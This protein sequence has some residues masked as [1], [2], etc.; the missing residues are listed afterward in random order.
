MGD[1]D[2]SD[3]FDPPVTPEGKKLREPVTLK[4]IRYYLDELPPLATDQISFLSP[5]ISEET[6][7]RRG[8]RSFDGTFAAKMGFPSGYGSGIAIPIRDG[9]GEI[10][11]V[12]LRFDNPPTFEK[13]GKR[14]KQRYL[15][16]PGLEARLDFPPRALER[17]E[18][19]MITEG[20]KKADAL[21]SLGLYAISVPGIWGWK[22]SRARKDLD[23]ID[24]ADRPVMIVFD[25]EEKPRTRVEV[26]KARK[27]LVWTLS[28]LGA[29]DIQVIDLPEIPGH[30]DKTGIDDFLREE[31]K[32]AAELLE[33]AKTPEAAWTRTL[34]RTQS[35][36]VRINTANLLT[37]LQN[38]VG[39]DFP[40]PRF[41][42]FHQTTFIGNNELE[43]PLLTKMCAV[44][45][46]RYAM[47]RIST[48]ILRG[49][50]E[51]LASENPF[52]PVRDW[53]DGLVWDGTPRI[54]GLFPGYFGSKE[55][56]YTRRAGKNFLI[57]SVARICRPGCQYDHM[58]VLE[59]EQ[60][61]RKTSS[62]WTLF[63]RENYTTA[64]HD[65]SGK[66]FKEGL[67]GFWVVEM[68]ELASFRKSEI[69][70]IKAEIS[71]P[72]DDI[73]LSYRRDRKRYL[74][75]CV[76][77]GTTNE[78]HFLSDSTGNRRF[79][80]IRCSIIQRESLERDRD[81]IWAE[82]V[83]RFKNGEDWWNVPESEATSEQEARFQVDTWEDRI[84]EWIEGKVDPT[85][86][87]ILTE[88]LGIEVGKH[89]RADQIRVGSI[90]RRMGLSP[91]QTSRNGVMVRV[92]GK[93]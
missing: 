47:G 32:S 87:D 18:P 61:I 5:P 29:E 28:R 91:R 9:K 64:Y 69:E 46:E 19:V 13:D 68:S 21:R 39:L 65:L 62:L 27:A 37:I 40:P 90:L 22:G 1:S 54:D 45:E 20:A 75:Q 85:T 35:G 44:I 42:E 6:I 60:G 8:Y 11:Q 50:I 78:E 81:Q 16:P 58:I 59:G 48:D 2:S 52:H 77:V 15:S 51:A 30:G 43:E 92:Y 55:T 82:A 89:T 14:K 84:G 3:S 41:D 80:P 93:S 25:R 73:R 88:C 12:Q 67:L 49:V 38:D 33:M 56:E 53:L 72:Y 31:R 71:K 7:A 83:H 70:I 76:F 63:G 36:D 10:V 17:E 24:W 66:D 34:I 79:W 86:G 23:Q 4:A 74:R 57:A 26:E